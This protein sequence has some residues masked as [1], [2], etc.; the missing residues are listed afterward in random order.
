[1]FAIVA[2]TLHADGRTNRPY[3]V[4]GSISNPTTVLQSIAQIQVTL[5]AVDAS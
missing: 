4:L 3:V 5:A 2:A 1:M